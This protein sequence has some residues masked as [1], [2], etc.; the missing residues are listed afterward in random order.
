MNKTVNKHL[1]KHNCI[2]NYTFIFG[3]ILLFIMYI[4]LKENKNKICTL[5]YF[6]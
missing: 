6:F 2:V 5:V 3:Y 1:A 4:L